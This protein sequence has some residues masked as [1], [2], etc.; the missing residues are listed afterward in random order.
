MTFDMH[1]PTDNPYMPL[2]VQNIVLNLDP[3]DL[4]FAHPLPD[5]FPCAPRLIDGGAPAM[6][7]AGL[8]HDDED[9]HIDDIDDDSSEALVPVEDH[10]FPSYFVE[11]GSP[12]RLFHSHGTYSLPVDGDEMKVCLTSFGNT[13]SCGHSIPLK[14]VILL[15]SGKKLSIFC[16]ARS[17]EATMTPLLFASYSITIPRNARSL[18]CVLALVFGMS[19]TPP[20]LLRSCC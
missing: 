17:S 9:S 2:R 10:D 4:N 12:Q 7:A 20:P 15:S 11:Y 3:H 1:D 19:S 6:S 18:I 13:C 16:F 5:L 8:E 14:N